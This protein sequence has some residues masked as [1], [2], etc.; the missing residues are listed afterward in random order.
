LIYVKPNGTTT[1]DSTM[2]DYSTSELHDGTLIG[3]VDE[4]GKAWHGA[5]HF[6]GWVPLEAAR[7][8]LTVNVVLDTPIVMNGDASRF[9]A[10]VDADTGYVFQMTSDIYKPPTYATVLLDEVELILDEAK[11]SLQVGSVVCLG[12][13]EKAVVQI[14]P[15]EGITVGGDRILPW[16]AAYSSLDSSWATGYKAVAT[17]VVCDNTAELSRRE[18]GTMY[19]RKNTKNSRLNVTKAREAIGLLFKGFEDLTEQ[20]E[21]LQATEVSERQFGM[22]L[23]HLFPMVGANGQPLE[24]AGMTRRDN[25]RQAI[26]HLWSTDARV[27][28]WANTA[29]GTLQAVNTWHHHVATVRGQGVKR[30]HRQ[31]ANLVE[32]KTASVDARTLEALSLVLG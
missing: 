22:V 11:G 25:N 9:R 23:D 6:M 5:G 15:T 2:S 27:A 7:E 24:R 28:P 16:L 8:L 13:K 26:R 30:Q 1:G 10:V 19:S 20:V 17:R 31:A 18:G 4:Y 12:H 29:W 14:R 21:R 3:K 32:G